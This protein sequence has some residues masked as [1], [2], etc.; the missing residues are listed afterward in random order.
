MSNLAE[1]FREGKYDELWQK[2]CGFIDLG[3]EDFM[4]NQRRLRLERLERQKKCELGRHITN[5]ASPSS[6]EELRE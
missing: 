6:V 4:R 3:L 2:C 1:L 5:G